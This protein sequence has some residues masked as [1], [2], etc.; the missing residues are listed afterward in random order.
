MLQKKEQKGKEENARC[1]YE[2]IISGVSSVSCL[3]TLVLN[4]LPLLIQYDFTVLNSE[5]KIT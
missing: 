5:V 1:T 2:A 4:E 3:V